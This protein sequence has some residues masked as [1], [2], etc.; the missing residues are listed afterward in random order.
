MGTPGPTCTTGNTP[1]GEV[2][3]ETSDE[4]VPEGVPT[5]GGAEEA[6]DDPAPTDS[7]GGPQEDEPG[8]HCAE[9]HV[10]TSE[11]AR[12]M[13]STPSRKVAEEASDE[14]APSN[15]R[16]GPRGDEPGEPCAEER[17]GTSEPARSHDSASSGEVAEETSDEPAPTDSLEG[18]REV[19]EEASDTPVPTDSLEGPQEDE[20][21]EHCADEHAGTSEP[22]HP[23][24]YTPIAPSRGVAEEGTSWTRAA[25]TMGLGAAAAR[26]ASQARS[27]ATR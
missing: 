18:P 5:R 21:G 1:S 9:E 14:P 20:L 12:P 15:S 6:S 23:I 10:G 24:E 3:E 25:R 19:A 13:D 4:T 16:G 22:A 17:V 7:L 11:P 27:S 2:A 26:R 8:G